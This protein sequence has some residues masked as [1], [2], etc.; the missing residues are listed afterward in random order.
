[1]EERSAAPGSRAAVAGP[2][3]ASAALRSYILLVVAAGAMAIAQSL[4]ALPSA[5]HPLEWFLFALL[6]VVTG[7]FTIKIAAISA[8]ISASDT[9]FITSTLLFGPAPATVA[10]ALDSFVMSW[11]RGHT[12]KRIAFNAVAPALSMWT[13]GQIFYVLARIE[14]LSTAY[15]PIGP[16]ILPLLCLTTV[17]FLLNSG[18]LAIAVGLETR[19]SPH[20]LWRRHFLWLSLSYLAAASVSFCLILLIQQ[21]S[22]G[23]VAVIL[24]VVA[25]FHLTLRSS[26][27]RL[28]DAHRH[29]AD[30]DRLYVSTIETLAMAI[31]AKDDVTHSHVRRVQAY[32]VAL[33]RALEITDEPTLKAIEAAALLHDTGKL[34]VPEHILNKPG[35][36]NEAEF[37]KMKEHVDVGA[38]ILSLVEFPFPVVPIVRCHHE[39]WDGTGYPRGVA[40]ADIPVGARILSVVDCYDALTSDRP[41]RPAMSDDA[42]LAILRERRGRMYDPQVVDTFIEIHL[43]V[44][45]SDGN[46]HERHQVL[47]QISRSRHSSTPPPAP[48][49]RASAASPVSDD[50]LAFVSLARLASGDVTLGD[51]LALSSKLI[52]DIMPAVTGA[53]YIHDTRSNRLTVTEAFGPAVHVLGDM[54]LGVGERL[55]GWVAANRQ[56]V[57]NSDAALDLGE[58]AASIKPPLLSCMS[59]PLMS[60]DSLLGVL[61]LYAA[62]R[63]AFTDDQGRLVQ[64]IVPHI[65]QAIWKANRNQRTDGAQPVAEKSQPAVARDLRLVT[66]R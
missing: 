42:A 17:Y 9:F 23:A 59:V 6:A 20:Q 47:Q 30:M 25:V 43:D 21:V 56:L 33:A 45:V 36:L 1:M 62:E 26:F 38:D 14:P 16:L 4:A 28:D 48:P 24:P 34:A 29:L 65:A 3:P 46:G 41:Y 32:A 44:A 49:V 31:D 18:L 27:G 52:H 66:S 37:E 13:A 58:R 10:V 8:R 2:R 53:W 5:P 15:K 35:K 19:Q 61:T 12:W 40:G 50:V 11:R 7:S 22:L 63:N 51:V 64:M 54:A 55:T 57:V 39:N 60:G